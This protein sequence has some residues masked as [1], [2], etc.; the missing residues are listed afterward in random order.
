MTHRVIGNL[1]AT[2]VIHTPKRSE[3][4][5]PKTL[6][7]KS[8]SQSI[9]NASWTAVTFDTEVKDDLGWFPGSGSR[10]TVD[11]GGIY[12]VEACCS[13]ANNADTTDRGVR[14]TV[15]GSNL[16]SDATTLLPTQ[17]EPAPSSSVD[18]RL[19]VCG[20]IYLEPGHYVEME[21]FQRTGGSNNITTS[22]TE[23]AWSH[24]GVTLFGRINNE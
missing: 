4:K 3:I 9:D 19:S 18:T 1:R 12:F 11:V 13:H 6:V 8:S 17:L 23:N 7:A 16:R 24:F 14:I 21:A 5:H 15:N 2:G 22:G 20:L 10:I